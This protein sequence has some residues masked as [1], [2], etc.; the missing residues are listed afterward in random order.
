MRLPFLSLCVALPALAFISFA[1]AA[2]A[3]SLAIEPVIVQLAPGQQAETLT[4]LNQSPVE[5]AFQVRA[6][7]WRIVD[8]EDV[9]TPTEDVLVSP[10]LGT[11]APE[12][13][14]LIRVVL[15]QPAREQEET[16]RIWIDQIPNATEPAGVR[17]AI[18]LSIPIFAAPATR[19]APDLRWQITRKGASL[20]LSVTN[21][22]T[23]HQ[24]AR[25]LTIVGADGTALKLEG[26]N[27][28]YILAGATR[29]WTVAAPLNGVDFRVTA[30][31]NDGPLDLTLKPQS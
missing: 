22:G 12:Q 5:S 28:P 19:T 26:N 27:S 16:Y 2:K 3:Q 31:T 13:R 7:S 8:G 15:R 20:I 21:N 4:L 29:S 10:P 6:F 17:I 25:N 23:R 1:S 11:I 18:R 14:Q 30:T 24:T 9:L